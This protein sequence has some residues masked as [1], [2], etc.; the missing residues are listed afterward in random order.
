M[1]IAASGGV[2][3]LGGIE[4]VVVLV[5]I[6]LVIILIYWRFRRPAWRAHRMP[7]WARRDKRIREAAAA[8]AAALLDDAKYVRPDAPGDHMDDL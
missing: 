2:T 5:V 8:D 4:V 3:L 6:A 1:R 7:W